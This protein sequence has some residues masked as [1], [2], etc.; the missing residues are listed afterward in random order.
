MKKEFLKHCLCNFQKKK[1][2]QCLGNWN[3][4][5]RSLIEL[6]LPK[7]SNIYASEYKLYLPDKDELR[8]KLQEWIQELED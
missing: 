8:K 3:N 1:P 4:P 6:T 5:C 2:K 7:D